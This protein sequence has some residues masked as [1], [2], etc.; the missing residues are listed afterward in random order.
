MPPTF[1]CSVCGKEHDGLPTDWGY[2][3]P[4][5]VWAIPEPERSQRAR[6]DTDLCQLGDRY[7][8]RGVLPVPLLESRGSFGWGAWAEVERPAFERY[9]ELYDQDG[10]AEP[11]F[12]GALANA[13][14]PY[15]GSMGSPVSIQLLDATTRPVLRVPETHES[16]LATDQR[17]GIGDARHHQ[18]LDIL[19]AD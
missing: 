19:R 13:L 18:I 10:S 8:I 14:R 7:F 6:F 11:S 12:A 3:L 17:T 4:D 15:P 5:D 9:L 1:I 16:L 2:T